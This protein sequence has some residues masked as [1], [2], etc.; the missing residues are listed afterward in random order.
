MQQVTKKNK[1]KVIAICS[2]GLD[3][4]AMASLYKNDDLTILSFNYGQKGIK[5]LKIAKEL[6][7]ELKADFKLVDI[8]FMKALYGDS[9]ALTSDNVEVSEDEKSLAN[10]PLRN[11]LFLQIAM[12]YA[13]SIGADLILMGSHL[14]D[15]EEING[16]RRYPDCSYEF[17]KT[18]ELAMDFGTY[19][20]DNK[21]R[22]VTPT[23]LGLDKNDLVTKGFKNLGDFIFKTWTCYKSGKKQCGKCEACLIRR[24]AFTISRIVD[25][26]IYG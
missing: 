19:K 13:Y 20:K 1:V 21:V 10:V 3:S 8:S 24:K 22:I 5:E 26:T 17:Y 11:G 18:F 9:N 14:T 16:E 23:T 4:S 25:K 12:C 15:A 6:A 7:K 2:G